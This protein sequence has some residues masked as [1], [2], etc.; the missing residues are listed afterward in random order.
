MSPSAP[1]PPAARPPGATS[2]GPAK[3]NWNLIN[4]R[5]HANFGMFAALTL[6][7]VAISCFVIAHKTPGATS[8]ILKQIHFGKFLPDST[9]WIW[10]DLQGLLLLWLIVSGWLIHWKTR[11][12]G[13]GKISADSAISSVVIYE[14]ESARA[15][16]LA[17]DLG[18]R[19]TARRQ[20]PILVRLSDHAQ[21]DWTR[22]ATVL[23][24]ADAAHPA[25][26]AAFQKALAARG[27]ATLKT[28]RAT[29]LT[30]A[31]FVAPDTS[32]NPSAP[33]ADSALL[34]ALVARGAKLLAPAQTCAPTDE[35]AASAWLD[36]TVSVIAPAAPAR[37]A[38]AR[39]PTTPQP[40]PVAAS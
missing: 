8:E 4:R 5:W 33:A 28:S 3:A 13:A 1:T 14:G 26:A 11:K 40:A 2:S 36:S 37:P 16:A 20:V 15:T 31:T 12:R 27:A 29:A 30:L 32:A 38:A 34:A 22:V 9:R 6:G 35:A 10:I 39:P 24:L 19:L 21:V 7:V 17:Q 25:G 23:V 18:K